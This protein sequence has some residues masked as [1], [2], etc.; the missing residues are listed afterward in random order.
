MG[1]K[2]LTDKS[3]VISRL[4]TVSGQKKTFVTTATVDV[5][6]QDYTPDSHTELHLTTDREWIMFWDIEAE[7]MVEEGDRVKYGDIFYKV[8]EKTINNYGINQHCEAILVEY[9]KD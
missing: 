4:K 3:V 5:A 2:D 1:I 8:K 9:N 7:D 6:F